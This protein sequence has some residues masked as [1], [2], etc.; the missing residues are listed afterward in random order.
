M[1]SVSFVCFPGNFI[2]LL[3][4][5]LLSLIDISMFLGGEGIANFT[6]GKLF[7]VTGDPQFLQMAYK[8]F[9]SHD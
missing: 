4:K 5:I 6:F 2:F 7:Y 9:E 8:C 1:S 3:Y